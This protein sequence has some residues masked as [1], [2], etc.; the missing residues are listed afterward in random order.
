MPGVLGPGWQAIGGEESHFGMVRVQDKPSAGPENLSKVKILMETALSLSL[1]KS[2][3]FD[4]REI[5][6]HPTNEQSTP[7]ASAQAMLAPA[8][9]TFQNGAHFEGR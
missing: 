7:Q 4:I 5:H 8:Q 9:A 3:G 6:L 1:E 2:L